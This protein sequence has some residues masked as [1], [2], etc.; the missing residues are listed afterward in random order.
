MILNPDIVKD[1]FKFGITSS[2]N[3]ID[4]GASISDYLKRRT[5]IGF[6]SKESITDVYNFLYTDRT[7]DL[8]LDFIYCIYTA[9]LS[10]GITIDDIKSSYRN[11]LEFIDS[12]NLKDNIKDM[13]IG[14]SK[15]EELDIIVFTLYFIRLYLGYFDSTLITINN[16]NNKKG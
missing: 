9:L 5:I 13:Y 16:I 14:N 4:I 1:I 8:K 12:N 7:Q 11:Y 2:V 10:Y 3:T 6:F 15:D